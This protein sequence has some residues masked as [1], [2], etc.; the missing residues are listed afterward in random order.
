MGIIENPIN[1]NITVRSQLIG[2]KLVNIFME[3]LDSRCEETEELFLES[4]VQSFTEL[5]T[6]QLEEIAGSSNPSEE[7]EL[8]DFQPSPKRPKY[9]QV[10]LEVKIKVVNM[11]REHPAWSLSTLQHQG[12][13]KLRH[14]GMLNIWEKEIHSGGT[15]YDKLNTIDKWVYDRFVEARGSNEQVTTRT[16]QEWGLAAAN[17]YLA[18]DFQFIASESWVIAFKKHHRIRQRKV[19]KLVSS[20][21]VY[22]MEEILNAADRFQKQTA[23]LIPHFDKN[24]V[25]NTDQTG[26]SYRCDVKRTLTNTG[27][28]SVLVAVGDVNKV[29]HSYTAQY[30]ITAAGRLL[31]K[32]FLCLQEPGGKFGPRVSETV[33]VLEAQYKNVAVTCSTSGKLTSRLFEQYLDTVLKPYVRKEKFLLLLDSWGGQT[34]GAIYDERFTDDDNMPT[35]TVKVIPPKCTPLCQPCDVYFYR[36]VKHFISRLQNCTYLLQQ[37]RQITSREDAIKIHSL[38]HNQL[39]APVFSH[40][41]Q[42]AWYA[43]KLV[44]D[45]NYVFRNVHE[46]CFPSEIRKKNC[47]CN[48]YSFLRCAWCRKFLCFVCFYDNFHPEACNNTAASMSSSC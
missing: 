47:D 37:K 27:E 24:F 38:V 44:Q 18:P 15:R 9:E 34:N 16:L 13:S 26:C 45:R 17:Q 10:P 12:S 20:K 36:Q 23:A 6:S 1:A 7:S 8:S 43:S 42:Y 28:R 41:L 29:T 5:P 33:N 4:E 3:T 48:N 39:S 11:A 19:T 21:E 31:P 35:S 22:S 25:I 30:S 2:E 32:V 40:M 14:K 46:V